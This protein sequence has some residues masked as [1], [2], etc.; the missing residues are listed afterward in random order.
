MLARST[1]ANEPARCAA[2]LPVLAQLPQ[3][4]ALVEVGASAGLCLLPDFYGYDYGAGVLRPEQHDGDFAVFSC[5]A[6]PEIP[7]PGRMPRI[8]WRAGLDLNP[9]DVTISE[10]TSWLET[11]V[12]PEQ[13]RRLDGLRGAL[14]VAAER[15]P[16]IVLGDLTSNALASLCREAP[17]EATLVVFHTAVLVYVSD[18]ADRQAFADKAMSLCPYWICNGAPHVMPE[19]ADRV[20]AL[21]QAGRFLCRSTAGRLPGPT[22]MALPWSGS[23][24][25]GAGPG[26]DH[27]H[28]F[29]RGHRLKPS[30]CRPAIGQKAQRRDRRQARSRRSAPVAQ[31]IHQ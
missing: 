17:P 1:Q 23:P 16:R 9:L 11:L 28:C 18:P 25:E 21:S 13:T 12:W 22:R 6:S 4:L 10:Q 8:V 27:R 15:K 24:P 30:S 29:G 26:P 19:I 3:P 14:R 20:G 5:A 7:L 2:L 31:R